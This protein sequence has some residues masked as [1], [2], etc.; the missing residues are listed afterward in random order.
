MGEPLN[1]KGGSAPQESNDSESAVTG[2]KLQKKITERLMDI[3]NELEKTISGF[4]RDELN[5]YKKHLTN[6]NTKYDGDVKDDKWSL[7]QAV[8]NMTQYF[9]KKMEHEDLADALHNELIGIQQC[10][11]KFELSKKCHYVCEGIAQQG[12]STD[13]NKIY[14]ELYI[15]EGGAGQVNKDHEVRLI[16]KNNVTRD[17]SQMEQEVQIECRTMFKPLPGQD[18]PIR[19]VL[20][21]GV[22]GIGKSICVQKFILDWAEGKDYQDIQFILP[23]P[24][25]ELNLKKGSQSLMEII[26]FFFPIIQGLT[27]SDR[28]KL[29][30][31]FD[32]LDECQLPLKFQTNETLNDVSKEAPLDVVMTNLIKGNLLPS[33]LIWITTRPA[34]AG[35]IPEEFVHRMT[36]LRGF[37]DEQKEQYFRKRISDPGLADKIIGHIRE[38]RSLHIMCHIPVFCWISATVLQKILLEAKSE[39]TPK[40]L[41]DM[42]TSFLIFQTI[43]GNLKYTGH[44]ASDVPWDTEGILSMGKLAFCHLEE[45]NLIFYTEDLEACGID[46]SRISVYSGLCT[47][48]TVRFLGTVFS[49]VHLSVQEF[50]AAL[51]AYI[52]FRNENKNVLDKRST[53]QDSNET[54]ITEFLKTAVDKALN[55][56]HGQMDL[57][58]RFLLGLSLES[59]EK[60]IRGLLTQKGRRSDSQKDIVD[61]IKLKFKENPSPERSINLFYC[62]NELNDDSLVKEIQSYM[63][64]GRLSEAELSPALWSA[65]VFVLLTS[66][67]K[68]DMFDLKKF[69][70]SDECLIRLLPV[71]KEATSALITEEGYTALASAVKSNPSSHLTDLDLRGNDPGDTGVEKLIDLLKVPEDKLTTLSLLNSSAAEE[72]YEYLTE[73]LGV[74][75]LLERELDL[76]GKIK[77]DSDLKMISHLLKDLHCRTQILKL[78]KSS[79]TEEGC[80]ALS[81]ALCLNPSHLIELDLSENELGNSGV[82]KICS[83]LSNQNCKLQT[84]G[85]SNSSITEK[86]CAALSSA[87]C[88]NPSHLI[89]LDLSENRLE[90]SG[91]TK[92]CSLLSNQNCKLQTLGQI[93]IAM[94]EDVVK[95]LERMTQLGVIAPMEEATEWISAIVA[96]RKKDGS[97]RLCIDPVHLNKALLR[98]CHPLRTVEQV[99]SDMPGA[100]IFTILDAKCGFWH[101]PLDEESSKLTTFMSPI[102]RY[103]FL[104][105]SYGISTGSEV[106]QRCMEQL[107]AGLPCDMVVDGLIWGRTL[108]EH[109]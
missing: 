103:A 90:N 29:M 85:L 100:K 59:N 88:L 9:L 93:R 4:I 17:K 27:L 50:L 72:A 74:N 3:F 52:S 31:I 68:I 41:T 98:P 65:L 55:C 15:T 11:L 71:V 25:R 69:I 94:K 97:V 6:R 57:F 96:A 104:R 39:D 13:L 101:I 61:Y 67:E 7:R 91:V 45:S 22:A 2:D 51:F 106:F 44:N 89:K 30:F 37:T 10:T 77:G 16:E 33:A 46:P 54:D 81:S 42:Y 34:A 26:N 47:Q 99:I 105:M 60:L 87:L 66:K 62:L 80:A 24:F 12:E 8:L 19:T 1:F 102:G 84:L 35:R 43:Q 64:S 63:S 48:E 70:R 109:D 92:V 107:F 73:V 58:L 56:G 38:S 49:F 40:T 79:I 32:G 28:Y 108:H 36:E 18:K 5:T 95:E 78:N 53:S 23:L 86:G 76:S 75:P 20:T 82:K 14:T 83:L 21:Q